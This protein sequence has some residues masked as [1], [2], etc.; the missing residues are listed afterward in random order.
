MTLAL[1]SKE[2]KSCFATP[3]KPPR[4]AKR[5]SSVD[6][7]VSE[8]DP[9]A[10]HRDDEESS[11]KVTSASSSRKS[12]PAQERKQSQFA[13]KDYKDL[14]PME[15]RLIETPRPGVNSWRHY[16]ILV[17][18]APGTTNA[19]EQSY[20]FP[21]YA[22]HLSKPAEAEQNRLRWKPA[23]FMLSKVSRDALDEIVEFMS[24]H[25]RAFW[26]IGHW[27][28]INQNLDD[29]SSNLAKEQKT[30]CDQVKKS[31]KRLANKWVDKGMRESLL[32]EPG[33]WTYPS[34]CCHWIVMDPSY[35]TIT[36]TPYSLE[37]QAKLLDQREPSRVQWNTCQSDADRVMDLP[38]A[39]RDKL[40]PVEHR[41]RHLVTLADFD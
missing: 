23:D 32:E 13:R 26:W 28:F 38:Q 12:R 21:D 4:E 35:K 9:V 14:L 25:R 34:K 37:E 33:V 3:G 6:T 8:S 10:E 20:G 36:G 31:Y 27:I 41:K 11:S 22:P 40:L 16:G 24:D 19:L 29:Y 30:K 1:H 5:R 39:T 15:R 7:S 17:K 2:S 18:F